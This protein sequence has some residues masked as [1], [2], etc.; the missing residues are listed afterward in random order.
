MLAFH[1]ELAGS[2]TKGHFKM[3]LQVYMHVVGLS[4]TT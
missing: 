1:L 3:A 2:Y 4:F